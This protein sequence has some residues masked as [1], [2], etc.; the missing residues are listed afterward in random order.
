MTDKMNSFVD[1]Q[2]KKLH[3]E[4]KRTWDAKLKR[5]DEQMEKAKESTKLAVKN[6][7]IDQEDVLFKK[8]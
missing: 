6:Y 4:S 8:K 3:A 1:D 7:E 2:K 5:L